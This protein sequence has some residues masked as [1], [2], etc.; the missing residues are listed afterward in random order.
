MGL[1]MLAEIKSPYFFV[2]HL[3]SILAHL[4]LYVPN[5]D[6]SVNARG[7]DLES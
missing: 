4:F 2:M 7:C 3:K 5:L 6:Y 1:N